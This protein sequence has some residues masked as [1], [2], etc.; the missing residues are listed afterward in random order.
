MAPLKDVSQ[1]EDVIS[2]LK[3]R[4]DVTAV[5]LLVATDTELQSITEGKARDLLD[6]LTMGIHLTYIRMKGD[7]DERNDQTD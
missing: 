7:K 3:G 1:Y 5:I 4:E 6:A 2:S